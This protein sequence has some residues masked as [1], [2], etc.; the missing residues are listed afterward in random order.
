MHLYSWSRRR[1]ITEQLCT[2][3]GDPLSTGCEVV[4]I[5]ANCK[6]MMDLGLY[7]DEKS[8]LSAVI[9]SAFKMSRQVCHVDDWCRV[10]ALVLYRQPPFSSGK[11]A[12]VVCQHGMRTPRKPPIRPFHL[13]NN[14]SS[15]KGPALCSA[16]VDTSTDCLRALFWVARP[17]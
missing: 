16:D 1:Y 15:L 2:S 17:L 10:L 7:L 5:T 4:L 6:G 11:P 14:D 12:P 13:L 3:V 8:L 9:V